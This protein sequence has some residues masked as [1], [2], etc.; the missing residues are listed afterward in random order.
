MKLPA[1]LLLGHRGSPSR[2]PENSL[3][4]LRLALEEGAH[5]VEFDVR[6]LADGTPVV[7][8]DDTFARTHGRELRVSDATLDD[9]GPLAET[10]GGA[11]STLEEVARWAAE[12]GAW[13]NIELKEDHLEEATVDAVRG[14]GIGERTF[15]SS[16]LPE[17]VG[18]LR[19]LDPGIAR[20]FLT[21]RWTA[22]E[23]RDARLIQPHGICLERGCA[24][25]GVVQ[26]IHKL[27]MEVVAWTVNDP[28]EAKGMFEMG[29]A[30]IIT[31]DPAGLAHLVPDAVPAAPE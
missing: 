16:F 13:L 9:L 29:V 2:A 15:V 7:V 26:R 3:A 24:V 31:N 21:K 30:A 22:A 23:E 17:V 14:A 20:C 28:R 27:G 10:P 25:P 19:R 12:S 11:V 4:G 8:H 1:P 6:G 5:G 18:R